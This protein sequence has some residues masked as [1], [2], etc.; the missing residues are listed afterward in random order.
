M[1]SNRDDD[2][3]LTD[4][5][6]DQLTKLNAALKAAR[7]KPVDTLG[8]LEH[9]LK[10]SYL[11]DIGVVGDDAVDEVIAVIDRYR[12]P[13]DPKLNPEP[14]RAR[15][16]PL[17]ARLG[18]FQAALTRLVGEQANL[19]P[20]VVAFRREHLPHGEPLL[21]YEVH[22]WI[23]EQ[24]ANQD[25]DLVMVTMPVPRRW[26]RQDTAPPPPAHLPVSRNSAAI[27]YLAPAQREQVPNDAVSPPN[28][29]T[30][31]EEFEDPLHFEH[32]VQPAAPGSVL[33]K[34]SELARRLGAIH[35][36]TEAQ[37]VT[38]VLTGHSPSI[39]MIR[40]TAVDA[41][42]V[43][44]ESCGWGDRVKLVVHPAATAQDVMAA[45][46]RARTELDLADFGKDRVRGPSVRNLLVVAFAAGHTG[47][48]KQIMQQ[49][50]EEHPEHQYSRVANFKRDVEDTRMLVLN[51]GYR[52]QGDAEISEDV[53]TAIEEFESRQPADDKDD[54]QRPE[55]G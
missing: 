49:W 31:D 11:E 15:V 46:I 21:P 39:A 24:V 20:R 27:R 17:G 35:G 7:K 18:A 47:S 40:Y 10:M 23:S 8:L 6:R 13:A 52:G 16:A 30:A 54:V 45:Y 2:L 26:R 28:K 14:S 43:D 55:Q 53:R 1:S 5:Q 22:A 38:L 37:A 25:N 29:L 3:Q 9:L 41:P 44:G 50:N 12:Q 42:V 32:F 48:W 36:W 19:D 4:D 33:M 34:L 51:F